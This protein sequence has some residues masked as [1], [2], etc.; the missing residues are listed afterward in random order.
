[1][2]ELNPTEDGNTKD[3]V[4]ESL[5]RD[6]ENDECW[7]EGEKDHDEAMEVVAVWV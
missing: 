7:R 6:G 2:F 1:M 3:E 5:V 4:E